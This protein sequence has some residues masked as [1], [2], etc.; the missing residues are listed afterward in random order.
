[1]T[2]FGKFKTSKI[3]K[4]GLAAPGVLL[5]KNDNIAYLLAAPSLALCKI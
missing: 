2:G 5:Y 4:T 1:M 3:S